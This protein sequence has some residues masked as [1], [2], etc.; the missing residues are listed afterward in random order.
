M[1]VTY[2]KE[3]TKEINAR[4]TLHKSWQTVWKRG[5]PDWSRRCA[6]QIKVSSDLLSP[7]LAIWLFREER[8]AV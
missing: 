5:F 4:K 7:T 8:P 3:K 6:A 2:A 1:A